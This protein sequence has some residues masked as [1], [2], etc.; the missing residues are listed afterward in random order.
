MKQEWID[1][2]LAIYSRH[3]LIDEKTIIQE[4][5]MLVIYQIASMADAD[6]ISLSKADIEAFNHRM[7]YIGNVG[8]S[9]RMAYREYLRYT[10]G[11]R[12]AKIA[13]AMMVYASKWHCS[14]VRNKEN[15]ASWANDLTAD[16]DMRHVDLR[17]SC[18]TVAIKMFDIPFISARWDFLYAWAEVY[19]IDLDWHIEQ[20]LK[21]D[22]FNLSKTRF[23]L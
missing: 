13:I 6:A 1:R 20:R 17:R 8:K 19:G 21:Y 5:D 9:F 22:E 15:I 11:D 23:L 3:G 18:I 10:V 12:L 7:E 14:F 2:A 4:T 16:A